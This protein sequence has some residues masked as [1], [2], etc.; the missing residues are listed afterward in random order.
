MEERTQGVGQ[1]RRGI[2]MEVVTA[3]QDLE[4]RM[5]D[6]AGQAVTHCAE[7]RLAPRD[8][9]SRTVHAGQRGV[10]NVLLGTQVGEE[11]RRLRKANDFLKHP[12]RG[13]LPLGN[14]LPNRLWKR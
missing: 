2:E 7:A 12:L 8:D 10:R 3:P 4:L 13:P 5:R 9:E 11:S 14:D 1:N 6:H